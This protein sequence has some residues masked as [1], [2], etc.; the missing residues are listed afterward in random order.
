[1]RKRLAIVLVVPVLSL[2]GCGGDKAPTTP[3]AKTKTVTFS[4]E[5]NSG[6]SGTATLTELGAA[7]TKVVISLTGSGPGPH[8]NHFHAGTCANLTKA[9]T[10]TLTPIVDGKGETTVPASFADLT[11][12]KFA[13]NVHKSAAEAAIY[14]ACADVP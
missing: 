5:S 6:I 8:P 10:H 14:V 12:G 7:S 1:M 9:P 2:V 11:G 3:T 4:Q 13:I